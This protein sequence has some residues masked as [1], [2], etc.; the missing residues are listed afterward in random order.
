MAI[1][2]PFSNGKAGRDLCHSAHSARPHFY[3]F[4]KN[5]SPSNLRIL[6]VNYLNMFDIPISTPR[7]AVNDTRTPLWVKCNVPCRLC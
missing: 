6:V 1:I 5:F 2:S 3:L 4:C 7:G